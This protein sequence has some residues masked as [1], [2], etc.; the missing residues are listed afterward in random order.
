MKK[1][2][3]NKIRTKV[4]SQIITKGHFKLQQTSY[5]SVWIPF[6][7]QKNQQFPGEKQAK[8]SNGLKN[9]SYYDKN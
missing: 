4:V 3:F 2:Q 1:T 6:K 9:I 8:F 5:D 7:P